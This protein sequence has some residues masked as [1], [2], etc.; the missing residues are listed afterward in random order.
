MCYRIDRQ[1]LGANPTRVLEGSVQNMVPLQYYFRRLRGLSDNMERISVRPDRCA[2]H[3][4]LYGLIPAHNGSA[5]HTIR[6]NRREGPHMPGRDR[7]V[8]GYVL[9]NSIIEKG[10]THQHP[11]RGPGLAK[12][13]GGGGCTFSRGFL[14]FLKE[15]GH[16]RD[17]HYCRAYV[18]GR[19]LFTPGAGDRLIG[20][21]LGSPM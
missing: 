10:R 3:T 14:I 11:P 1:K 7:T 17:A 15:R 9:G 18:L 8:V 12:I 2:R 6:T 5:L 4:S 16:K 19:F 21:F 20:G 13:G